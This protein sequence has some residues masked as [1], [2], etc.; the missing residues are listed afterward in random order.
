MTLKNKIFEFI[1]LI[2]PTQWIKNFFIFASIIFSGNLFNKTLFVNNIFTFFIFCLISSAVYIFNDIID[3]KTDKVHPQKK[4]RPIASGKVSKS[5][6]IMLFTVVFIIFLSIS[7]NFN[8]KVFIICLM[9]LFINIAYSI[10]LK[11]IV[12]IDVMIIT[13]G[14]VLRVECGSIATGVK[15]SSWLILCTILL[16]LFIALNKRKSEIIMLKTNSTSHRKILQEYSINLINNML[17]IITPSVFICYCLYTF[18][19]SQ[20]KTMMY[21][22]PFVLYGIFRYEYLMEKYNIGGKPED[23][24]KKDAPFLINI[25]LWIFSIIIIIYLRL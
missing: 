25:L 23:I 1:K 15:V 20:S 9:Y 19:S 2:R 6:G 8:K 14:F 24:F 3:E 12:I 11:N 10:V 18:S 4:Y 7:L 22:I 17:S 16:S 21:T 5:Q 13:L